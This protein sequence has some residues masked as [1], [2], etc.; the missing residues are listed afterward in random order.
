MGRARISINPYYSQLI[1]DLNNGD[2]AFKNHF[3]MLPSFKSVFFYECCVW[4]RSF[5]LKLFRQQ[6]EMTLDEAADE[7]PFGSSVVPAVS[8]YIG[9]GKVGVGGSQEEC[10]GR[11][12]GR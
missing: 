12:N 9:D 1:D 10:E 11:R 5:C 6:G 2:L 8:C 4:A 3:P 7:L